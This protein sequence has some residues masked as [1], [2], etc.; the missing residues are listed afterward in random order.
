MKMS[1]FPNNVLSR[2]RKR[3]SWNVPRPPT[4]IFFFLKK[5]G[6]QVC[7]FLM[8][9]HLVLAATPNH[10]FNSW[11]PFDAMTTLARGFV[12]CNIGNILDLE[13]RNNF[14]KYINFTFKDL[15]IFRK[16][17]RLFYPTWK[18][19]QLC[20]QNRHVC[21]PSPGTQSPR[22]SSGRHLKRMA[23]NNIGLTKVNQG[24]SQVHSV[25]PESTTAL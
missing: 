12:E 6:A 19:F 16:I 11:A 1:E 2:D 18:K 3:S 8:I 17:P 22:L 7:P 13:R 25:S 10:G 4:N 9:L 5:E 15:L 23:Q 24:S 14:S 20:Q 21:C